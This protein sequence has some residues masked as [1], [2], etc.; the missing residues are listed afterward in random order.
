[1]VLVSS[2]WAVFHA[3]GA[4]LGP[5]S[6]VSR[7]GSRY[8]A[9]TRCRKGRCIWQFQI[10]RNSNHNFNLLSAS[11]VRRMVEFVE[12]W[13][14]WI[15]T[16][17]AATVA[18]AFED[19]S[20]A[21]NVNFVRMHPGRSA[22]LDARRAPSLSTTRNDCCSATVSFYSLPGWTN[23]VLLEPVCR[24]SSCQKHCP[25]RNTCKVGNS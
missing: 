1:L 20:G 13:M 10:D 22:A 12:V 24:R 9:T 18:T 17:H 6:S 4:L 23:R 21:R 7:L 2:D 14:I 16:G 11:V 3:A 25:G 8:R 5:R 15:E 19:A